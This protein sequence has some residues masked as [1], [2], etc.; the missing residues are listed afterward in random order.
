MD[1]KTELYLHLLV[2]VAFAAA[3]MFLG[4]WWHR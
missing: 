2:L 4:W 1:I 3:V